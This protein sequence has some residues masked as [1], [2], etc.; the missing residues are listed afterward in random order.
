MRTYVVVLLSV[1][2]LIII[3][4]GHR[5]Y[6]ALTFAGIIVLICIAQAWLD[7]RRWPRWGHSEHRHR[8]RWAYGVHAVE[9]CVWCLHL[10]SPKMAMGPRSRSIGVSDKAIL[11]AAYI[12]RK[13][14]ARII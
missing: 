1:I 3:A 4:T 9:G 13:S 5:R 11:P 8:A 10:T 7:I 14:R 2:W 12:L 6:V